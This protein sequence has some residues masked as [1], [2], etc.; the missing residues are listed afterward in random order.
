MAGFCISG[1]AYLLRGSVFI[2]CS[3]WLI[4]SDVLVLIFLSPLPKMRAVF[5]GSVSI[6]PPQQ[7]GDRV[8][9]HQDR[10]LGLMDCLCP[11][12]LHRDHC[13]L[14]SSVVSG[15]TLLSES[16][17]LVVSLIKWDPAQSRCRTR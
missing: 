2:K 14:H 6:S 10:C 7:R 11:S 4:F 3:G 17:E 1:V 16:R 5:P 8:R 13:R 12:A 9:I 15:K